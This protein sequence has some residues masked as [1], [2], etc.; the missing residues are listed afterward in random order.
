MFFSK[1]SIQ[2]YNSTNSN[3]NNNNNNN[4]NFIINNGI[5]NFIEFWTFITN[6]IYFYFFYVG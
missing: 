2:K 1:L 6:D 4:N 3:S 5:R